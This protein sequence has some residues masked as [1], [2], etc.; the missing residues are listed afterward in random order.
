M[1]RRTKRRGSQTACPLPPS[2]GPARSSTEDSKAKS[3]FVPRKRSVLPPPPPPPLLNPRLWN[4]RIHP[5]DAA[6]S[7][8]GVWET[9]RRVPVCRQTI[10]LQ[11]YENKHTYTHVTRTQRLARKKGEPGGSG[12]RKRSDWAAV[13]TSQ[14]LEELSVC[15]C[16]NVCLHGN[17]SGT[18]DAPAADEEA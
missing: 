1:W 11:I 8:K 13:V 3:P 15:V 6:T 16:S 4:W 7:W 18:D 10:S 2:L 17:T 5:L 9:S 12:N 14:V